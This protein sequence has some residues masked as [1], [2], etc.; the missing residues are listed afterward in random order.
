M[1]LP[2]YRPH[3]VLL[4]VAEHDGMVIF[5]IRHVECAVSYYA[6]C[7]IMRRTRALRTVRL[8]SLCESLPKRHS[9]TSCRRWLHRA[10]SLPL[11]VVATLRE[12]S[13]HPDLDRTNVAVSRST[14]RRTADIA[15][16]VR[17]ISRA[18]AG[19]IHGAAPRAVEPTAPAGCPGP[20]DEAA[21]VALVPH[22]VTVCPSAAV[23][24]ARWRCLRGLRRLRYR[25]FRTGGTSSLDQRGASH[26]DRDREC[27]C[28]RQS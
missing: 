15:V 19:P 23:Q 2:I 4:L 12:T 26:A 17:D 27:P 24:K 14:A 22:G 7:H 11:E 13:P 9:S 18:R 5:D 3:R 28:N 10:P 8:D 1:R 25:V 21:A 16:A 6:V 20:D